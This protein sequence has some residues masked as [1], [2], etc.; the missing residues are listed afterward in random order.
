MSSTILLA[1]DSPTIHKVLRL[2][3]SD[4]P[5]D[6]QVVDN[7]VDALRKVEEFSPD[8]ILA[9]VSLTGKD[10]Y[11]ICAEIKAKYSTPVI[12]LYGA[13]ENVDEKRL[14]KVQADGSLKKPF[15]TQELFK[16]I[17]ALIGKQKLFNEPEVQTTK[18]EETIVSGHDMEE[19]VFNETLEQNVESPIKEKQKEDVDLS[20]L[21]D[22]LVVPPKDKASKK[23]PSTTVEDTYTIPPIVTDV[24]SENNEKMVQELAKEIIEKVAWEVVP[25]IAERIVKEKIQ[26]LLD[27]VE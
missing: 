14:E 8:L 23:T 9:D 1:D 13:F 18:L 21:D 25:Q 24:K 6:L 22:E 5:Y 20:Y 4:S 10:G 12:I 27:E 11:Q 19:L 2:A 16:L 15:A 7:G 17:H 26:K 3:L